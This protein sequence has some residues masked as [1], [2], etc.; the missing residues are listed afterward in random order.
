[1]PPATVVSLDEVGIVLNEA[2]RNSCI[3]FTK[4][5]NEAL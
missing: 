3:D 1:M 4:Y 2:N 5:S